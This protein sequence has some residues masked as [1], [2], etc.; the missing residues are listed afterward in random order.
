MRIL[1]DT[2]VVLDVLLKREPFYAMG[3]ELLHLARYVEIE[4]YVSA[5]AVTD[6]YYVAQ[7]TTKE[8]E[9]AANLLRQLFF[10]FVGIVKVSD[11][12]IKNA[13]TLAWDDFE[14]AVQYSAALSANVDAII[15]RDQSGY[16]RAQIPVYTP[17][18]FL[19]HFQESME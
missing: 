2:N 6:I 4:E 17:N 19:M 8:A 14:D 7:R 3:K 11:V 13:L 18:A 12:V 16:S 1:L 15:T 5:S 9:V 10:F